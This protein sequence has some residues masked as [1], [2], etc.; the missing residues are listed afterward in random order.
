MLNTH[1]Q[2]KLEE[3]KTQLAPCESQ[4]E[5]F[6]FFHKRWTPGTCDWILR[7]PTFEDWAGEKEDC[8]TIFWLDALPGSGKSIL[9]SFIIHHLLR[10]SLC[11]YY[12]F[13]FG[14]RG[15]RSLSSC[16]R[17]IAFQLAEKLPQFRR[18]LR[19][20]HF[21]TRTAEKTDG[22]TIWDKVFIGV[23]FNIKLTT[24]IYCVIDALDES[25]HPQLLVELMRNLPEYSARLKILLVSR[26]TPELISTFDRVSVA[27]PS[28]YLPVENTKKDIR[29]YVQH[30]VQFMHAPQKFKEQ[31]VE[32]LVAGANG[33]FLWASLAL[34]EVM[35]C[36][37]QEDIDATLEG[38][39]SGMEDFYQ[40]MEQ[41][42]IEK[43]KP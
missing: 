4:D 10:N 9:S 6:E 32:K 1:S 25:D 40:R 2:S 27:V 30:E 19:E 16:L 26:Q 38:M 20:V 12:F 3:L 43:T 31:I 17:T 5:D 41:K 34:V 13:R 22:K 37:T 24:T 18:A 23:L 29:T 42:I 35:E 21:T 15:K 7:T 33:S 11:V 14:D 28:Q 36:N 8:T 39:P